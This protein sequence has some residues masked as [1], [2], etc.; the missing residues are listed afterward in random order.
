MK[1]WIVSAAATLTLIGGVWAG[2]VWAQ[3]T[4]AGSETVAKPRKKPAADTSGTAASPDSDLAPIPS[5]LSP[6]ATKDNQPESDATFRAETNVVNV[7][8]QVLDNHG[9]PIPNI[10]RENFRILEDNVPQT[11]T[12]YSVAQAPMTV[13]MV[14][15]FSARYQAYY[16]SGWAQALTASY[17]FLQTLKPDDY[18]AIIAYD[19]RTTILS[20]FTND[21]SRSMEAMQRL[22]IP[23]FSES[24]MFDALADTA[25]RMQ[26]IEGRKAI[27]L[28]ASGI[29][30]FSKL[31]YDKARK[32]LQ[33]A[34]VPVYSIEMLQIQRIMAET[35][36]SA[37]QNLDFL[38][39][40]N[41][42]KTFAKETGGQAFF[43]RFQGELPGVF[44]AISQ[45][46]RNQYSLGFS[47]N[48]TAKDGKFRKL[49]IQLVNPGTNEPLKMLDQKT[50]KP[51]KYT[52]LAKAGYTA[53]RAVE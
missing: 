22:R 40:D 38:Q 13:A 11:L 30:T 8:V 12:Q 29:D 15:E 33:E 21:R 19:L 51:I 20:D 2:A 31:T 27:L 48:N 53:P 4:G 46:L 23:G 43:P 1:K 6:K 9:N 26:K 47:S 34:G 41:E 10:P 32:A 49:T 50:G 35:R 14:I 5:K 37:T 7:D 17:G 3:D 45:S 39:A 16:S 52:I 28:I 25:D 24:N 42:L 44:Q 18:V 36:M